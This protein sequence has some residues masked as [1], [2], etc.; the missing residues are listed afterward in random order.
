M[1]AA[2]CA[3]L[4]NM[5]SAGSPNTFLPLKLMDNFWASILKLCKYSFFSLNFHQSVLTI[6]NNFCLKESLSEDY[7]A[8]SI[9]AGQHVS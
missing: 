7:Q 4:I 6:A 3:S 8:V 5:V 2:H 1:E 9:N